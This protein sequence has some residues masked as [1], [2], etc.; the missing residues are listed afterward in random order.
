MNMNLSLTQI[1]GGAA[2]LVGVFL[3]VFVYT[4]SSAPIEQ[5]FQG[6]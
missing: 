1:F 4:A 6:A 5:L 2:L 3:L